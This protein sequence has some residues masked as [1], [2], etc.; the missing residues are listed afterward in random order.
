MLVTLEGIDGSG[1]TSVWEALADAFPVHLISMDSAQVYRGLD[2]GSAKPDAATLERYPHAL[3]DLREPE[4]AYSAAD[5]ALDAAA[6]MHAAA[7][8]GRLPVLVGGTLLY[9]RAL[10]RP[11]DPLP[12]ADAGLRERLAAEAGERGWDALHE[13]L[14]Q[15][16]PESARRIRPGDSQRILRALEVHALTGRPLSR[17]QTEPPPRRWPTLRLVITPSQRHILH[18]RIAERFDA[19]L[20]DG[21]LAEVEALRRRPDLDPDQPSMRA[22]GYRQAWRHL[23]GHTEHR[24][25]RD[26]AVAA[27]RQ[28]AKRQLTGLRQV[29]GALWYDSDANATI[30]RILRRVGTF[31]RAVGD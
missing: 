30:N 27:T 23:E 13:R 15:V 24:A 11:L 26:A 1:K 31:Y 8:A 28:L 25:F 9:F 29:A 18:E 5:F 20:A 12:A 17:Q 4:D 14:A 21:F 19:M 6:E 3:I 2:I 16:D 22:V 7:A 10:V